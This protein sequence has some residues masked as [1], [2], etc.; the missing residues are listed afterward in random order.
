[1]FLKFI[2]I[3]FYFLSSACLVQSE[4]IPHSE[5]FILTPLTEKN[6]HQF[7]E[8]FVPAI[9]RVYASL[10]KMDMGEK[11]DE[12]RQV[13]LAECAE[14][15]VIHAISGKNPQKKQLI[16]KDKSNKIVAYMSFILKDNKTIDLIELI[17]DNNH[18]KAREIYHGLNNWLLKNNPDAETIK[19]VLGKKNKERITL[20]K[21]MGYEY[22]P[23]I[24]TLKTYGFSPDYLQ[25]VTL[26]RSGNKA[27]NS[28]AVTLILENTLSVPTN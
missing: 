13:F 8:F 19:F 10:G 9:L 5:S 26:K 23:E 22:D 17:V 24:E 28:P 7:R 14:G 4:K 21:S 1:M 3:I 11:N 18:S 2:L 15:E 16:L 25:V 27:T 20:F 12:D 6:A